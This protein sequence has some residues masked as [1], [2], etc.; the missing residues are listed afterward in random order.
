VEV[1]QA[2]RA[3]AQ[4]EISTNKPLIYDIG[5]VGLGYLGLIFATV[6]AESGGTVIGIDRLRER[7]EMTNNGI[8]HFT[9]TGLPDAL[10]GLRNPAN[11]LRRSTST[12]A[13]RATP[14]SLPSGPG[15]QVP[16]PAPSTGSRRRPATSRKTCATAP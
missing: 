9:E 3:N 16:A 15:A 8:P 2:D 12:R 7:V 11:L 5:V 14:T 6:L 1:D 4:A 13:L 10:A